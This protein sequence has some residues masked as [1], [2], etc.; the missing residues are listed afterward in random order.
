MDATCLRDKILCQGEVRGWVS[1][2]GSGSVG[3][4]QLAS[5]LLIESPDYSKFVNELVIRVTNLHRTAAWVYLWVRFQVLELMQYLS[6][7]VK[8]SPNLKV[9]HRKINS[10]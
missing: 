7:Q 8:M 3:T 6:M 10:S 2:K 9:A 4:F 5:L 1:L